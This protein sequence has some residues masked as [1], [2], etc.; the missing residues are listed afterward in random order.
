MVSNVTYS[1]PMETWHTLSCS[2]EAEGKTEIDKMRKR[3]NF[4]NF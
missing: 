1:L 4:S 3:V 2:T